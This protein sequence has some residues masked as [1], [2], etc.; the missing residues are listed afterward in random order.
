MAAVRPPTKGEE[1][2]AKE[3]PGAK[4]AMLIRASGAAM[5]EPAVAPIPPAKAPSAVDLGGG[6]TR[7]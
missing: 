6:A 3:E 5:Q 4:P 7:L 1:G 2:P